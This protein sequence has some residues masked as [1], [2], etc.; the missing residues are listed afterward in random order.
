[1]SWHNTSNLN[2]SPLVKLYQTLAVAVVVRVDLFRFKIDSDFGCIW[3][4][5][6]K[7]VMANW[8]NDNSR[9]FIVCRSCHRIL[10]NDHNV[11]IGHY[12][13]MGFVI[14]VEFEAHLNIISRFIRKHPNTFILHLHL[15]FLQA[16]FS[17]A[18]TSIITIKTFYYIDCVNV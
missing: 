6:N 4:S 1:M 7:R 5:T 11:E 2:D 10:H 12:R 18:G 16:I 9:K 14:L 8:W 15:T 3:R 13:Y 17:C